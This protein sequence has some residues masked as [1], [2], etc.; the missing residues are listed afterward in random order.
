MFNLHYQITASADI[1]RNDFAFRCLVVFGYFLVLDDA[2]YQCCV[3]SATVSKRATAK[4]AKRQGL[5]GIV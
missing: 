3:M 2:C 1:G 4:E 5:F